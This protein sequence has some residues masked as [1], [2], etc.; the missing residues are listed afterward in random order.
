[1]SHHDRTLTDTQILDLIG[2]QAAIDL[3]RAAHYSRVVN[4]IIGRAEGVDSE[5]EAAR[6]RDD[7]DLDFWTEELRFAQGALG[8]AREI[9]QAVFLA[10]AD[11]PSAYTVGSNSVYRRA[12]SLMIFMQAMATDPED[13]KDD[14]LIPLRDAARARY[15]QRPHYEED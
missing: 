14:T 10:T 13:M 7:E 9:G 11:R 15:E 2:D 4:D 12:E 3:Y 8:R 6:I 1:M 5:E